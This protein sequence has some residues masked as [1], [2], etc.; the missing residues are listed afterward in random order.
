MPT[1]STFFFYST[2]Y[3]SQHLY[4]KI[5][6]NDQ[7]PNEKYLQHRTQ[8]FVED[9]FDAEVER[10]YRVSEFSKVFGKQFIRTK[11]LLSSNFFFSIVQEIQVESEQYHIMIYRRVA[12]RTCISL[13]EQSIG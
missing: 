3:P 12:P 9:F 13:R 2:L 11:R 10:V 1:I 7:K 6:N 4:K 8:E 5:C